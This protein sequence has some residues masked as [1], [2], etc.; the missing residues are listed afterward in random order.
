MF[1][2]HI[3]VGIPFKVFIA[4]PIKVVSRAK[5]RGSSDEKLLS[6]RFLFELFNNK[7]KFYIM[8]KHGKIFVNPIRLICN[9]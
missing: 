7:N 5:V 9:S 3:F 1:V 6:E 4:F 8:A 2:C